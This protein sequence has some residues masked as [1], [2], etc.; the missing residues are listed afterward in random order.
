MNACLD[1]AL[2]LVGLGYRVLP[3]NPVEKKPL[4][5][6]VPNGLKNATKSETVVRTWWRARPDANL[7]VETSGCCVVDLDPCDGRPN[8]W[9]NTLDEPLVTN[10]TSTTP[11]GGS[12]LWYADPTGVLKNSASKLAPNVDTR[13][14][15]GYVLV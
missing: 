8:E 15:N 13:A 11:R 3:I 14:T 4:A 7:A 9:L 10:M 12:H 1:E 2:R 6:L 5:D